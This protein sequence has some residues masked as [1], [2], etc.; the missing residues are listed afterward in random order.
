[1]ISTRIY[2]E[3]EEHKDFPPV[4][5]MI[6]PHPSPL[7]PKNFY[8]ENSVKVLDGFLTSKEL[9]IIDKSCGSP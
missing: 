2:L 3:G 1:M 7:P 9:A 8:I 6:P 4:V 5:L